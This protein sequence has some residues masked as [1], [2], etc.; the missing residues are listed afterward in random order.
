MATKNPIVVDDTVIL[1]FK[2]TC[3]CLLGFILFLSV[4]TIRFAHEIRKQQNTI[5]ELTTTVEDLE[6]RL[7]LSDKDLTHTTKTVDAVAALIQRLGKASPKEAERLAILEVGY[8]RKHNVDLS[9]GLALS[10]QE[11]KW[12]PAVVSYDGSSFGVKQINLSAWRSTFKEMTVAKLIKPEYNIDIGYRLL[13]R[14]I[15]EHG[16]M[17][18]ALQRYRGSTLPETN[19]KY[20]AEVLKMSHAIRKQIV[21][22]G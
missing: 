2:I 4:V 20:A 14:H 21:F 3:L 13:S 10:F 9:V 7:L 5:E 12:R 1:Y 16:S 18:K 11:S 15:E 8:A 22:S 19:E 6:S 17:S